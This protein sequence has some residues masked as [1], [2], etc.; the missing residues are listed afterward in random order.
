MRTL[1]KARHHP[2]RAGC[3]SASPNICHR[4]GPTFLSRPSRV[5][6]AEHEPDPK[7]PGKTFEKLHLGDYVWVT[8]SQMSGR[9]DALATALLAAGAPLTKGSRVVIYGETKADWQVA[10]QAV[11]RQGGAVVT[12]YATLGQASCDTRARTTCA[13]A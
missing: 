2:S 6:Q 7:N 10:A 12:I 8:Y 11:F 13:A 4:L 1:I 9:V 5:T 3:V